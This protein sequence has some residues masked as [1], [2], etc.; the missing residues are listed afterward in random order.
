MKKCSVATKNPAAKNSKKGN[1]VRN[2]PEIKSSLNSV[3]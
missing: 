1:V 3:G 2:V